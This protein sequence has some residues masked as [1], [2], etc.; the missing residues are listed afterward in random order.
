M[1]TGDPEFEFA[2]NQLI[3][4]AMNLKFGSGQQNNIAE[5][6]FEYHK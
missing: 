1:A 6:Y 3:R 2:K 5:K 4:E